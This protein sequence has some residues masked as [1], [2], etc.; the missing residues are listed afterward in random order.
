MPAQFR[1]GQMFEEKKETS[2]DWVL[3]P[4]VQGFIFFAF[5]NDFTNCGNPYLY[6]Q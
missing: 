2:K 6:C 3:D 4:V 1:P 5:S